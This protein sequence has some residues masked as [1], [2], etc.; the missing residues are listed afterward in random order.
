MLIAN[1]VFF[2]NQ[3]DNVGVFKHKVVGTYNNNT[4]KHDCLTNHKF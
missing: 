4:F 3:I 1:G 2:I